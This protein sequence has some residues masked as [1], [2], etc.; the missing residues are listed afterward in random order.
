M[1]QQPA[2]TVR[3]LPDGRTFAVE[4]GESIVDAIRRAGYRTPYRCRNGGCRTCIADLVAGEVTYPT[5]VADSALTPAE[6]AEGACLPCRA[7]PVGGVVLQLRNEGRLLA[8]FGH[9]VT[10]PSES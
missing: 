2:S 1:R 6:R 10:K 9:L 4:P 7:V 8:I 5:P 3:V